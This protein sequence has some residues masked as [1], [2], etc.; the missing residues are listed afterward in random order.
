MT[1]VDIA[2]LVRS[3]RA[4]PKL[5]GHRGAAPVDVPALEDLI[6]RLSCLA[7]ELPEVAALELNPVVVAGTGAAVLHAA[8]RLARPAE[9]ADAVRRQLPAG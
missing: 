9:R 6:G 4:A 3:V 2:D 8:V 1:D 7:D 5:F